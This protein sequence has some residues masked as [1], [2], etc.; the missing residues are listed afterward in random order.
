MN[1]KQKDILIMGTALFAMF[2]GAGNLIFPPSLGL[3]AGK[4]WITC[5]IGFF[6]TAIGMP[7]ITIIAVCR[8]GGTIDD[9]GNKIGPKF[10]KIIATIIILAI[11]PLFAIPRTAAT[12]FETGIKPSLPGASQLIVSIIFFAVTL[13]FVINPS[14]T[15]DKIAKILTPLLLIIMFL[16]IIKGII[17]PLGHPVTKMTT[18]P[19]PKG[20][21]EG[22][23]TMDA[24]ASLLFAGVVINSIKN[25]GYISKNEQISMTIKA[26][27]ISSIALAVIYGGLMYLGASTN[28]IFPIDK[29]K[30][31]LLIAIT[32][33]SLGDFGKIA[34]G[35]VVS[36]A[37]LTTSVGLTATVGN[38]FNEFSNNKVSYRTVV[39]ITVVFST[40]VSNIGLD[41]LVSCTL[42]VLVTMYPVAIVLVL[43]NLASNILPKNSYIGAI[44]A[45]FLVS[46]YDGFKIAG[47]NMSS[48]GNII[49]Y[50][51]FA[52]AG[53]FWIVPAFIGGLL[54]TLLL[55]K[56]TKCTSLL[57]DKN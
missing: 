5:G 51:P 17:A 23:Q 49:S 40:I 4:D 37:C 24:L 45:T 33:M 6:I 2:F 53:F 50:L 57:S 42:P 43:M 41:T 13:Y 25:K 48:I 14:E 27:I 29:P 46:L 16:L 31:D 11:G 30:G 32:Y 56:T 54:S 39:I 28:S 1:K 22:Y 15:I 38:Y 21:T 44:I 26:G 8:A 18:S 35:L 55:N 52:K 9:M 47:F 19:F 34:L 20:F 12:T 10:S 36:L 7:L 3:M